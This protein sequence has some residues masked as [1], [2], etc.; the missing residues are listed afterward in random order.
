MKHISESIIGRKGGTYNSS[1]IPGDWYPGQ[2]LEYGDIIVS[3]WK[4]MYYICLPVKQCIGWWGRYDG[5]RAQTALIRYSPSGARYTSNLASDY[6][7]VRYIREYKNIKTPEDLK[8][9]FD[10]YNIPH[11]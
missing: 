3:N 2:D 1:K 11:E 7:F 9:I 6:Q 4:N 5:P 8:R 10:K